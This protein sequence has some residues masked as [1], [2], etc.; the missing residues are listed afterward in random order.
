[1]LSM[2]RSQVSILSN[3]TLVPCHT[4]PDLASML[5]ETYPCY[6]TISIVQYIAESLIHSVL[7][8]HYSNVVRWYGIKPLPSV[9]AYDQAYAN[10]KDTNFI[11]SHLEINTPLG[12]RTRYAGYIKVAGNNFGRRK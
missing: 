9:F 11:I 1:M 3:S 6:T 12:K 7:D 4:L 10:N 8:P 5:Y 2:Y